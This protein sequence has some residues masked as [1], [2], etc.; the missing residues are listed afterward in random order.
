MTL[1]T[2][3]RMRGPG[4]LF[5][6]QTRGSAAVRFV[7][8]TVWVFA[9]QII[10]VMATSNIDSPAHELFFRTFWLALLLL[11]FWGMGRLLD[12]QESPI[13]A[14]GLIRREGFG[15]EIALGVATGWGLI[16]VLVLPIM[17]SGRL[18]LTFWW[19]ARS[20]LL[21]MNNLIV[22]AV[23]ALVEEVAFRGYAFQRLRDAVGPTVATLLLAAVFGLVHLNN[24]HGGWPA[25]FVTMLA[26]IMLSV[27]YLQTRSLWMA[28]GL[29]FG[30]NASMGVL[31]GLPVSGLD[32]SSV[33][34]AHPGLPFWLTGGLYGPEASVLAP[35]VVLAGIA[36]VVGVTRDLNWKYGFDPIVA[37]GYPMDAPPPPQHAAMEAEAAAKQAALIQIMPASAPLPVAPRADEQSDFPS[38]E[39]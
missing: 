26:G 22:L 38:G 32:F 25:V 8:G 29:H 39:K 10:A 33:V 13:K 6:G 14:M 19:S 16:T 35:F 37:G 7:F 11:G 31:F 18:D 24:P 2:Q 3:D 34:Q 12:G 21:T 20:I 36:V 5:G 4:G 27:A 23:A 9:S 17:L 30:W 28:W 15:K 1:Q